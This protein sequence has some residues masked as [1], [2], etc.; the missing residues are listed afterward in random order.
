MRLVSNS[1]NINIMS[2]NKKLPGIFLLTSV[3][4]GTLLMSGC[5]EDPTLPVL[6]T[7]EAIEITTISATVGGNVTEDG[8]A[9]VTVRGVCWGTAAMPTLEDNF[10]ASGTGPG[11]FSC[12]IDGLDPNTEYY[13][14]AYAENSVGVAYGNEVIFT[15]G[16]AS[17]SV[18]TGQVTGVTDHSAICN[19]TVTYNGGATNTEK[20]ICWSPSPDPDLDDSHVSVTTGSDTYSGTLTGL[21]SGTRYYARAYVKNEGGTAYGEQVVFVTKVADIEGNLYGAV[22]IGDQV[23]MTEN[24][25]TTR[26]NDSSVIPVV[27]DDSTWVHLETPAYCWL[28]NEIQYKDIYGALYNWFTVETGKLCPSGWHVPSDDEYKI[29]EQTLGMAADQLNLDEWRGTDQGAKMKSST[30]WD[31][32]ENG[33]NSSGFSALPGGYRW[34]KNGAFNGIGMLSYWWS[35]EL[36]DEYGWYRRLDGSHSDVFR[37]GTSKTGGKYIRCIKNSD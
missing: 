12:I 34:A 36:N 5:V 37:S 29:L 23:W 4:T 35:S 3:L 28:R 32:G 10:K 33:I 25:K 9:E 7:D 13:A 21:T 19:G 31:E 11:E 15:T 6:T 17:P 14:R 2:G 1:N 24:L 22:Y 20:G 30:G 8:G 16:I 18:A 26:F 27:A